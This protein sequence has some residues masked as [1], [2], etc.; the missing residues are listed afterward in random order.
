MK[1]IY[2]HILV[3]ILSVIIF[4]CSITSSYI[5]AYATDEDVSHGGGGNAHGATWETK[6][7]AFWCDLNMRS[8]YI[9]AQLGR[10]IMVIFCKLWRIMMLCLM[11][12]EL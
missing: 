9:L 8:G 3:Y 6:V 5:T 11:L 10:L 12:M 1:K 4:F 7:A 2:K